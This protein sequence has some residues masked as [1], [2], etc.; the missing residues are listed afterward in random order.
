MVSNLGSI[1]AEQSYSLVGF[2]NTATFA[3]LYN[4]N[5][6]PGET[7][8]ALDQLTYSGGRTNHAD[9]INVCRDSLASS[10]N[11][12]KNLILLITDGDPSMPLGSPQVDAEQAAA[13]A[14]SDG[15]F[16]IPV[17][18]LPRF[19]YQETYLQGISS[20]GSVFS[21]SDFDVLD[22][23]HESLLAQVSCQV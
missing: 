16:I 20:D 12:G 10:T 15:I 14:K 13:G 23:L 21:V 4:D 2:G 8:V 5:N 9:A 18:I 17:M 1:Q 3:S 19:L 11:N 7:N 6:S 22:G